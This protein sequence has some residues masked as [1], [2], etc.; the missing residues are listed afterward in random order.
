MRKLHAPEMP[1][2]RRAWIGVLV[3]LFPFLSLV[4]AYGIGLSGILFVAT[5]PAFRGEAGTMLRRHWHA[6]RWVVLAF[7]AALLLELL[8]ALTRSH[9]PFGAALERPARML[10][11]VCAMLLV[12]VGKP[13]RR[14]L[15]L[16]VAAGA[17]SALLLVAWQRW[18]LGIARPGG[19][20]N[21]ITFGNLA[22]CLALLSLGALVELRSWPRSLAP[23][24]GALAGLAASLLSGSR[25]GWI[26]LLF[27]LPVLV[28]HR[29]LLPSK[30]AV[31]MVALAGLLL[32]AVLC[33]PQTGVRQRLAGAADDIGSY[34][35]GKPTATSLS[36]RLEL[37]KAAR[38]LIR[39]HPLTGQETDAYKERMRKW[40]AQG[41]LKPIVFAPPE[42]PHLHNDALQVLVTRG[43]PGFAIW[44]ATLIAPLLFFSRMLGGAPGAVYARRAPALAGTLLVLAYFGFGF[45]EVMFWSLKGCLFYALTVFLLMGFCLNGRDEESAAA[46]ARAQQARQGQLS[47]QDI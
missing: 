1:G 47:T 38:M 15:W 41:R 5:V 10:L 7:L 2:K 4:S 9:E 30:L 40:V 26:V 35:D 24:A 33:L 3:F 25:G 6:T 45:T 20:I 43:I 36:I 11:A 8:Y 14:S 46:S 19:L 18:G 23:M 44:S 39:E 16:G 13:D 22:L 12:Q 31:A 34:V 27:A 28:R 42:P 21:P 37:W 17:L 29:R 32:A